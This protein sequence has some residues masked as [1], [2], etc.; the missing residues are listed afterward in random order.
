MTSAT[1]ALM[2]G[3][4]DS[5]HGQGPRTLAIDIGGSAV[6]AMLL[7]EKGAALTERQVV[8]RRAD[9]AGVALDDDVL[10]RVRRY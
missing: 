3:K 7:D 8:F 1:P 10:R 2:E 4:A 9:V 6:K 5:G